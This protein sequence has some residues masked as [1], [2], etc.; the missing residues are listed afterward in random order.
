MNTPTEVHAMHV[1]LSFASGNC[2]A[3]RPAL[4]EPDDSVPPQSWHDAAR[5]GRLRPSIVGGVPLNPD[6]TLLRG[7]PL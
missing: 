4:P 3:C 5:A 1:R 6:P 7:E 2:E